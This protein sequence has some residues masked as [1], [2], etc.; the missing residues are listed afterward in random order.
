MNLLELKARFGELC[1]EEKKSQSHAQAIIAEMQKIWNEI[2][3][4]EAKVK[5]DDIS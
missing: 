2:I 4:E 3:A 5:A 1:I